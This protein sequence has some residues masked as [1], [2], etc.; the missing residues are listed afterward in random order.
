MIYSTD[1]IGD[2]VKKNDIRGRKPKEW[3]KAGNMYYFVSPHDARILCEK[4]KVDR[5]PE[6]WLMREIA[7]SR[8][9]VIIHNNRASFL[10]DVLNRII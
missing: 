8:D 3:Y 4:C 10:V 2:K 9:L 5:P 7:R 1:K 6:D